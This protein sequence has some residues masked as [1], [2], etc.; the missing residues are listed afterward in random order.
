MVPA[1]NNPVNERDIQVVNTAYRIATS[2]PMQDTSGTIPFLEFMSQFEPYLKQHLG[3][4]Y[5]EANW[6]ER[7]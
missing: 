1:L 3:D 5:F 4:R 7:W 6:C 2:S